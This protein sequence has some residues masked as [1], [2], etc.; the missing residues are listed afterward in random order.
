LYLT[1]QAAGAAGPSTY[2]G[3]AAK[4]S[5]GDVLFTDE[6]ANVTLQ[7]KG[8]NVPAGKHVRIT[9]SMI[10]GT[11][12]VSG[13]TQVINVTSV[14]NV[15]G[16]CKSLTA[17]KAAAGGAAA[18]GAGGAAAAGAAGAAAGAAAGG[19]SG[20]TIALIGVGVAAAAGGGI[21]AASGGHSSSSPT[22][23]VSAGRVGAFN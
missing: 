7:L 1:P 3:C 2:T 6:T 16:A 14:K 15:S 23:T 10:P 12:P 5:S 13:A 17:V 21:A 19:L 18:A 11:N 4:S 22:P 9:G 8:V 20:T